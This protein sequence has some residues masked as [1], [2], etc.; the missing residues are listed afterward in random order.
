[1]KKFI[2]P[3]IILIFS[4]NHVTG[5]AP[6]S[7]PMDSTHTFK[8]GKVFITGGYGVGAFSGAVTSIISAVPGYS[9]NTLGPIYGKCEF[10]VSDNV[11]LGFQVAY[12]KN[13]I[14]YQLQEPFN[15]KFIDAR[16][17]HI[18]MSYLVRFNYHFSVKHPRFD[19]YF[20]LATGY[21]TAK[22]NIS[23]SDPTYT[24][25]TSF[26]GIIPIGFELTT[27]CRFMF[28]KSVGAYVELGLAKSVLQG[29]LTIRI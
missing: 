22:Y 25:R 23:Y 26:K 19:P 27:G 15:G 3:L 28:T 12:L 9:V 10:A 17:D 24:G 4:I 13:N 8:N 29:G 5:K 21:R 18:T 1:M 11:G 14:M 7:K 2:I 16:I 6:A 20:G